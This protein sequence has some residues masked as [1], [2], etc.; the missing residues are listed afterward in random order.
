MK[1]LSD[2]FS[3]STFGSSCAFLFLR[4]VSAPHPFSSL[5][6]SLASGSH[7]FP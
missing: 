7:P 1:V 6:T 5:P 2:G 3:V 4:F